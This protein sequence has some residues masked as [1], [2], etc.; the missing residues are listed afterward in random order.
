MEKIKAL[1]SSLWHPPFKFKFFVHKLGNS[2]LLPEDVVKVFYLT[3]LFFGLA[4]LKIIVWI[5]IS[6]YVIS[7]KPSLNPQVELCCL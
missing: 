1:C 7:R 5:I 3:F 4:P 6:L 2:S